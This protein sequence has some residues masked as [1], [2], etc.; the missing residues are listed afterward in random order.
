MR[1]TRALTAPSLPD[2][3]PLRTQCEVFTNGLVQTDIG[4][5]GCS[6][7]AP[8]GPEG[9]K[10]IR[11]WCAKPRKNMI[12]MMEKPDDRCVRARALDVEPARTRGARP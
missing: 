3:P 7:Q 11:T 2:A 6:F 8:H 5:L 4:K 12:P 1:A 10:T 9:D